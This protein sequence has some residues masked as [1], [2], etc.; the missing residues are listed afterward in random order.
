M[1]LE[2]PANPTIRC[3]DL[4]VLSKLG[5][6]HNLTV[7]ADNTFATP[8][9]QQPFKYHIDYIVHSTTK[10][11]N[12]HGTAIG[13]VLVGRDFD[14]M[15]VMMKVKNSLGAC[16]NAFDAFLLTN[17]LKTFP[18]RMERHCANAKG[19]YELYTIS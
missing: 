6:E 12:G 10:Y 15:K 13:G 14:K 17:G 3:V 9:L 5:K 19:K 18:L 2:T 16:A 4:E 11:L 7:V 8:Y 1:Y